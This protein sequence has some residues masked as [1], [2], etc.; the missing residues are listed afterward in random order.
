MSGSTRIVCVAIM[1]AACSGCLGNDE[2]AK[3]DLVQKGKAYAAQKRYPEAIIE[4]KKAAQ[5][6][7]RFADAYYELGQAYAASGDLRN[8]LPAYTRAGDLAPD[9]GEANLKAGN[10]MLLSRQVQDAKTRA[11]A[12]LVKDPKNVQ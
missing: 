10:L 8:A 1:V 5:R 4:F 6:D 3:R 11:R 2:A 9:N 7:V 12:I